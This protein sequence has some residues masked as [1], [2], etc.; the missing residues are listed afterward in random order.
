MDT[1][2]ESIKIRIIAWNTI[3]RNEVSSA[4]HKPDLDLTLKVIK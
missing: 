3:S 1:N 2:S 4:G